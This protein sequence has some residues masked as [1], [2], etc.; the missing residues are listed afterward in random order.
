MGTS[1]VT[2]YLGGAAS[3]I[4]AGDWQFLALNNGIVQEWGVSS[5]LSPADIDLASMHPELNTAGNIIAIA[6]GGNHNLA[7]T[8]AGSVFCW[9]PGNSS[10]AVSVNLPPI[11]PS[12]Q[13]DFD[14][15]QAT[16]PS[17]ATKN[18]YWIAG[19][20]FHS[21]AIIRP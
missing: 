6:A 11:G 10:D 20:G 15:G 19:G 1:V 7:I 12:S 5:F 21:L 8:K 18:V 13:G 16:V 14:F 3:Q 4:A 17:I 9:G 2:P